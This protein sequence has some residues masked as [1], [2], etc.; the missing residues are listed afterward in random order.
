LEKYPNLHGVLLDMPDLIPVA[1]KKFP[2]SDPGVASRLEYVGG[3]MFEM[4]PRGDAYVLKH[5]IHDWDD[6]HSL[7]LLQNCHKSMESNGRL[8]CVDTVLPP[9]GDVSG[10]P[11]KLLDVLMMVGIEGKERTRQQWE[12]LYRATGFRITSI[13]PLYDNFGTSIIEGLKL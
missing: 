11:A 13:T 6:P 10:T 12:D 8:I 1:K 5:I 3:D 2:V 9:M 7:R 4:M